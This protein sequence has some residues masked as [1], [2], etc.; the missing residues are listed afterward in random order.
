MANPTKKGYTKAGEVAIYPLQSQGEFVM[1]TAHPSSNKIGVFRLGNGKIYT[2]EEYGFL[3]IG[4]GKHSGADRISETFIDSNKFN[5]LGLTKAI[6]RV[7]NPADIY[8]MT[9]EAG[10]Y[11]WYAAT[12]LNLKE[13]VIGEIVK[14]A[15][16]SIGG[17]ATPNGSQFDQELTSTLIKLIYKFAIAVEHDLEAS[18]RYEVGTFRPNPLPSTALFLDVLIQSHASS[19]ED[20]AVWKN[21]VLSPLGFELWNSI[22]E[23]TLGSIRLITEKLLI[24]F[25]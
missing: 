21:D 22:E 19:L 13:E 24:T 5:S 20:Q 4:I 8:A 14:G 16:T 9:L 6:R 23:A 12:V 25:E 7:R 11:F 2:P 15:R 1:S 3:A 17:M 18:R 10:I